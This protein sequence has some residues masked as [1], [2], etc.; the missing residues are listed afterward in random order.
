MNQYLEIG[1]IV[2]VRGLK[3]EVKV[4]S[5]S[6]DP[7]RFEKIETIISSTIPIITTIMQPALLMPLFLFLTVQPG[8]E[9]EL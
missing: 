6:E 5:Y 3:G 4:N 7:N 8:L 9:L 2:N 1:Q